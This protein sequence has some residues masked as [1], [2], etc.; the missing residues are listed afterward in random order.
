MPTPPNTK[1]EPA[2]GGSFIYLL[3]Q[4]PG[5][6]TL[7]EIDMHLG[8]VL[9]AVSETGKKAELTLKLVFAR[10]GSKGVKITGEVVPKLPKPERSV[11]FA[12]VG[13]NGELLKNDPDQMQMALTV[14][15]G[16]QTAAP[17]AAP[18]TPIA[19]AAN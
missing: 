18:A 4:H 14:A 3:Q 5:G 7:G 10:N 6:I 19:V 9:T 1:T 8:E 17:V 2:V 16:G 12:Y 11:T 15:D 13:A